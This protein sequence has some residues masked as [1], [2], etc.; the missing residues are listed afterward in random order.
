MKGNK[1]DRLLKN[2]NIQIC[3]PNWLQDVRLLS[4]VTK[5]L[6]VCM[7]ASSRHGEHWGQNHWATNQRH[8]METVCSRDK[9]ISASW[10]EGRWTHNLLQDSSSSLCFLNRKCSVP[11]PPR[12]LNSPSG[13][14]TPDV[15]SSHYASVRPSPWQSHNLTFVLGIILKIQAIVS[16]SSTLGFFKALFTHVCSSRL[17]KHKLHYLSV[18]CPAVKS[19]RIWKEWGW[20]KSFLSW[21]V[22]EFVATKAPL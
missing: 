21:L 20:V 3:P 22:L 2:T 17:I 18:S 6:I 16:Q 1:R 9:N 5:R 13:E 7:K 14:H 19:H 4:K 15:P 10:W 8:V 12:S 11:I